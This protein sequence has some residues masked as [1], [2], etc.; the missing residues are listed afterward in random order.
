MS[1]FEEQVAVITGGAMGIGGATSRK[2]ASEGARVLIADI[3]LD[4][5]EENVKRISAEGGVAKAI[6]TDVSSHEDI[7]AMIAAAVDEWGRL[8]ILVQNAY[9]VAT[10]HDQS[11][12]S[13]VT[14]SE[15][16]WDRGM[17]V[18]AKALYL[19]AKYAVPAMSENGGGNIVNLA[20]VHGVLMAPKMLIYEA[21]KAAVIGMT[22]QMAI[23]FGPEGIRVNA[24]CPGHILTEGLAKHW[25]GNEDGLKFF[26]D[27]YPVKRV[28]RPED[29]ANAIGFLCSE[30]A[31]F[32][33]GHA[34]FVDGGHTIQL[35]EN[36]GVQQAMYAREHPELKFP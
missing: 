9:G 12:G 3:D 32:I 19:G 24:I 27:Q 6:R 33:T 7:R 25:E 34:L 15:D 36:F 10:N 35:Q 13:A 18:L 21:G 31:S 4:A 22:K 11:L 28:G 14:V 23:D 29:I 17:A 16:A 26:V 2:L 8:D 20:S 30:D 5:A 1:R